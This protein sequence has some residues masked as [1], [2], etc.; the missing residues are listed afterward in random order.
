M[1]IELTDTLGFDSFGL[2]APPAQISTIEGATDIVTLDN[3]LSTYFTENKREWSNS[4]S[5]MSEEEYST[6]KGYYDRQ[7][8]TFQFPLLTID[9]LN[10]SG[11]VVRMYLNTQSVINNCG[12]VE[13]VEV[14]FRE[15]VQN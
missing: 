15:T 4:W 11:Q 14:R 2:V 13:G 5:Y 9:Q 1:N 12:L 6:L 3:N 7:W 10:V 8:T